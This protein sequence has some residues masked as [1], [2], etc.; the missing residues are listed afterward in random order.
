MPTAMETPA[1][2]TTPEPTPAPLPLTEQAAL[3]LQAAKEAR[4][5]ALRAR[6]SSR[7]DVV[8]DYRVRETESEVRKAQGWVDQLAR[9]RDSLRMAIPE[10]QRTLFTE[11]SQLA[12]LVETHRKAE[13]RQAMLVKQARADLERLRTDLLTVA[14][15]ALP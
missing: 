9:S 14:G 8:L 7:S 15:E 13:T 10:A 12:A 1:D 6:D 5:A 3:R 4:N 2:V 11:E